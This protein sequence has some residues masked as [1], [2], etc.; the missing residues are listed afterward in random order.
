M[1]MQIGTMPMTRTRVDDDGKVTTG[2]VRADDHGNGK[3]YL[4]VDAD[5]EVGDIVEYKLP[6]GKPRTMKI[7][8]HD[9]MQAPGGMRMDSDLDHTVC[10][11]EVVSAKPS[12]QPKRVN[13]PGLHESISDASGAQ[14]ADGHYDEAI[15]TAFKAVEDRVKKHRA[16]HQR[17]LH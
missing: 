11:Y 7:V 17:A 1:L 10:E 14:F 12:R 9:V 3:L 16:R 2:E 6:N 8:K 13:I 15:F 4:G 5:I